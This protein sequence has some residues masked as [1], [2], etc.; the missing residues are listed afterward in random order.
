MDD[1]FSSNCL[2]VYSPHLYVDVSI[3]FSGLSE[4]LGTAGCLFKICII[5]NKL[6][7]W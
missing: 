2:F 1:T 3:I 4:G 5:E 6:F 7:H